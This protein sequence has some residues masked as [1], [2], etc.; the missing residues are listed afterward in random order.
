MNAFFNSQLS[1]CLL[2][3]MC[4]GCKNNKKIN[5][6]QWKMLFI[7]NNKQSSFSELL[8]M[9]GS[10]FIHMRNIQSLAIK[11]FRYSRYLSPP[12]MNDIF[13]QKDNS[14]EANF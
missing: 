4:H 3:C 5:R 6:F 1:Y 13:T 11:M 9:D 2:I 10:V 12:V 7:Y 8:E 14:L